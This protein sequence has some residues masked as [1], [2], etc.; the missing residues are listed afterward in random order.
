MFVCSLRASMK[1]SLMVGSCPGCT[2]TQLV[3]LTIILV[4]GLWAC[5]WE[6]WHSV[7][8]GVDNSHKQT[9]FWY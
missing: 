7:V 2:D 8:I 4:E 3:G 1:L 9:E 6:L 5:L